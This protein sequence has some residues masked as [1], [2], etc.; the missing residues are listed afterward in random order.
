MI[1]IIPA[2]LPKSLEDLREHLS[3]IRHGTRAVQ[4]DIVDGIFAPNKTWPYLKHASFEKVVS[5]EEGLP[6]WEEFDFEFDLM[7]EKPVSEVEHFVRAGGSRI[8]IHSRSSDARHA[9]EKLQPM[10]AGEFAIAVGI[11]LGARATPDDLVPHRGMYDFVQV[12]GIDHEG[13]QGQPFDENV[14]KLIST[15]R[16]L[17]PELIVQVDGGV[18]IDTASM[19]AEAGARRLVVGSAIFGAPDAINAA[20]ELH[21]LLN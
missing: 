18:T 17:H 9:L 21:A 3:R 20:R 4:V 15:L 14:L 19:L 7:L 13:F 10:R 8:I 16:S 1:E 2:I 5:E 6:F 11:A 12:M